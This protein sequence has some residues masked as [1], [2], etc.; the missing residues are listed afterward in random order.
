M[1]F[2]FIVIVLLF[3]SVISDNFF[4]W[5]ILFVLYGNIIIIG[6]LFL[7]VYFVVKIVINLFFFRLVIYGKWFC[8]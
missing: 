5:V 8:K 2:N 1:W 6:G 4:V 7:F 3:C